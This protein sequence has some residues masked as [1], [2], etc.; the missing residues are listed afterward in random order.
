MTTVC[1]GRGGDLIKPTEIVSRYLNKVASFPWGTGEL[2]HP[3]LLLLAFAEWRG[4]R[5]FPGKMGFEAN[6]GAPP[7]DDN[8]TFGS[9]Q[10]QHHYAGDW[11]PPPSYCHSHF[12]HFLPVARL[13]LAIQF[14]N[15]CC[16]R[17]H[18]LLIVCIP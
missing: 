10:K 13:F 8:I 12:L 2:S 14:L 17:P 7:L 15:G 6:A 9:C 1:M 3:Q 5:K 11:G 16:Y 4:G 18:S